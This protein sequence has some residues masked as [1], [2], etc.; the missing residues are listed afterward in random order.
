MNLQQEFLRCSNPRQIF[1]SAHCYYFIYLFGFLSW[2]AQVWF[3]TKETSPTDNYRR[4]CFFQLFS[5]KLIPCH[6]KCSRLQWRVWWKASTAFDQ[7]SHVVYC[8]LC[9]Q[10]ARICN[11]FQHLCCKLIKLSAC[12]TKDKSEFLKMFLHR[13]FPKCLPFFF[14]V[15]PVSPG[16]LLWVYSPNKPPCCG[17]SAAWLRSS[18]P[19]VTD[20]ALH[21]WISTVS[22]LRLHS[23]NINTALCCV[24]VEVTDEMCFCSSEETSLASGPARTPEAIASI[25]RL[26]QDYYCASHIFIPRLLTTLVTMLT[27]GVFGPQEPYHSLRNL[28]LR[29]YPLITSD[30]AGTVNCFSS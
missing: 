16:S 1:V 30:T 17:V 14:R 6:F 28:F 8:L 13:A 5:S 12:T 2:K 21:E 22:I 18:W 25:S 27:V 7:V 26:M 24:S 4:V 20:G 3:R 19:E 23:S 10:K 15:G 9:C 11:M 29:T